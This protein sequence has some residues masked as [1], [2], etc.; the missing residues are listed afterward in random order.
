[1][2]NTT[3]MTSFV[4]DH[5]S[6]KWIL[7]IASNFSFDEIVNKQVTYILFPEPCVSVAADPTTREVQKY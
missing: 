4:C 2:G 5:A 1:M 7:S 3:G 6:L